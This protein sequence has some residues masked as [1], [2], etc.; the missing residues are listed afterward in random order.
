MSLY[1]A[2]K[3]AVEWNP[4]I[5]DK[6]KEIRLQI[7]IIYI[8]ILSIT[9]VMRPLNFGSRS[10]YF[11]HFVWFFM[12]VKIS[13]KK[14]WSVVRDFKWTSLKATLPDNLLDGGGGLFLLTHLTLHQMNFFQIGDRK[15][16]SDMIKYIITLRNVLLSKI[17]KQLFHQGKFSIHFWRQYVSL[18]ASIILLLLSSLLTSDRKSS[19][20]L[21][22]MFKLVIVVKNWTNY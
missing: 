12:K 19:R 17:C 15:I 8:E 1:H 14:I 9:G 5:T 6:I 22:L 16:N 2:P 4:E 18:F 13:S 3:T 10:I 20:W 7:R 11:W 21:D